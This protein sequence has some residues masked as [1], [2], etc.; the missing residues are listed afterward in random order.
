MTK[1]ENDRLLE[2]S[3]PIDPEADA[4]P[5]VPSGAAAES[6]PIVR[7]WKALG[8]LGTVFDEK[9]PRRRWLLRRAE[10]GVFPLGKLGI[11][12]AA[13]G[14][15]KT[16][17]CVQLALAVATGRKWLEAFDMAPEGI[18]RVLLA[19]GEEDEEEVRR[20]M[21]N[22]ARAMSLGERERRDALERIVVL[23]LAGCHVA[24]TQ[25]DDSAGSI[26]T[27]AANVLRRK[28]DEESDWRL[29]VLDPLSR[30]AGPDAE[31]N[32]AAAT[33]FIE[34][35]ESL[36]KVPGA[37][38]VLV[39]HHSAQHARAGDLR[40]AG[41]PR[42]A[43][44]VA[45]G[46]TG[47]TDGARWVASLD[48]LHTGLEEEQLAHLGVLT[49][50]KN[51]YAPMMHDPILLRRLRDHGGALRALDAYDIQRVK[52]RALMQVSTV[53]GDVDEIAGLRIPRGGIG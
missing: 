34:T 10:D 6:H 37:P 18:G 14:V 17:A 25:N 48:S 22:A 44:L 32:N 47:I 21:Y 23:P 27:E 50:V 43:S 16:M 24:L 2:G 38:A 41:E 46:A 19:L 4:A 45:R 52:E 30:F 29:V 42:D 5:M 53:A 20:R 33:R 7:Q 26:D 35:A 15:G 13:G 39:V 31:T 1:D 40:R 28:M 51:N 9:P 8:E 3:L 12:A 11:L 36:C 49:I